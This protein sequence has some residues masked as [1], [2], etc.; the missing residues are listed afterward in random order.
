MEARFKDAEAPVPWEL[1]LQQ[2]KGS[3]Q[4]PGWRFFFCAMSSHQLLFC[5]YVMHFLVSIAAS[6]KGDDWNPRYGQL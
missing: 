1:E 5:D 2:L 3:F 6:Y 4:W